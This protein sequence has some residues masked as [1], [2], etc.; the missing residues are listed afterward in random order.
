MGTSN[1][2]FSAF[3][4]ATFSYIGYR[5]LEEIPTLCTALSHGFSVGNLK[6]SS[7]NNGGGDQKNDSAGSK[8]NSSPSSSNEGGSKPSGSLNQNPIS[9]A[10]A[11]FRGKGAA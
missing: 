5:I 3:G 9:S 8:D 11:P 2:L 7:G 1:I 10:G 4:I 6:S